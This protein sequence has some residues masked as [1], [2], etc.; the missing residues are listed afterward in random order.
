M[1]K[2]LTAD[3]NADF[4]KGFWVGLGVMTSVVVVGLATKI[5]HV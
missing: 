5:I 2:N 4:K 3:L 1:I